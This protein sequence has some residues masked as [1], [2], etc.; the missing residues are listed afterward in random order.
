MCVSL[1]VRHF[2]SKNALEVVD[3]AVRRM[4]HDESRVIDETSYQQLVNVMNNSEL[5]GHEGLISN[6]GV[7]RIAVHDFY[8]VWSLF[9]LFQDLPIG[10]TSNPYKDTVW[11]QWHLCALRHCNALAHSFMIT[12]Y[13][14]MTEMEKKQQEEEGEADGEEDELHGLP[15]AVDL[16]LIGLSESKRRNGHSGSATFASV[17]G[18]LLVDSS[19]IDGRNHAGHHSGS[20][21]IDL[22][23]HLIQ[24]N[25]I[26]RDDDIVLEVYALI[27][28]ATAARDYTNWFK[29]FNELATNQLHLLKTK[30]SETFITLCDLN[31]T[32]RKNM[33][34]VM[35]TCGVEDE[36][37]RQ[38]PIS[39]ELLTVMIPRMARDMVRM[40]TRHGNLC[41]DAKLYDEA[42]E[43]FSRAMQVSDLVADDQYD[44]YTWFQAE[45][46]D[47]FLDQIRRAGILL[48]EAGKMSGINHDVTHRI[49][50]RPTRDD[51]DFHQES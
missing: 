19:V 2:N 21:R 32:A 38:R 4:I 48:L 16:L 26:N 28:I 17:N 14:R 12:G 35:S 31:E 34:L 7:V 47:D 6:S 39:D 37:T 3:E 46:M 13:Q 33:K 30:G 45:E 24:E 20:G 49:Q 1:A 51:E 18:I 10:I 5:F 23:E 36:R 50:I 15:P 40:H 42:A 29:Q 27:K 9:M 22:V 43:Y 25:V 11:S 41:M 8:R 44:L